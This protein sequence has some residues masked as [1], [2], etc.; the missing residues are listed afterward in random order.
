MS[1]VTMKTELAGIKGPAGSPHLLKNPVITDFFGDG[2]AILAKGSCDRSER[3][4]FVERGSNV[5]T[6]IKC[7]MFTHK[8]FPP[9]V[10]EA[11]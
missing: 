4:L 8:N 3:F 1:L 9:V 11:A 2:S 10:R 7:Q 6:V 5:R